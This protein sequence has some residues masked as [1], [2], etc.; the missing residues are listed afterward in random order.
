[1]PDYWRD[2]HYPVAPTAWRIRPSNSSQAAGSGTGSADF[3]HELAAIIHDGRRAAAEAC[4]P[5]APSP[6]RLS[7]P[8]PPC[9]VARTGS[10]PLPVAGPI[11]GKGLAMV[12]TRDLAEVATIELMRRRAPPSRCLW[13]ASIWLVRTR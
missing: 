3:G 1:M 12:D 6:R 10:D 5:A 2:C 8:W 11:G 7:P 13:S 4:A 9:A